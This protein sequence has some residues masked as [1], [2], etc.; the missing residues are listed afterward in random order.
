MSKA[1]TEGYDSIMNMQA[2]CG[3]TRAI[4]NG[5]QSVQD[6]REA[7]ERG[8]ISKDDDNH[9]DFFAGI[10]RATAILAIEH[11]EH[12]FSRQ[13]IILAL[14]LGDMLMLNM[15]RAVFAN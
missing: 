4:E 14:D 11:A 2:V 9:A 13:Y 6:F 12:T 1:Y 10:E 5:K 8:L 15:A 7:V 3:T